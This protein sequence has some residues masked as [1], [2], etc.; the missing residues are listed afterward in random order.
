LDNTDVLAIIKELVN[1]SF[2]NDD[3]FIQNKLKKVVELKNK[4]KKD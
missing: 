2:K 1:K 3:S 4:L